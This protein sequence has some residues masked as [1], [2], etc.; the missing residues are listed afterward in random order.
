MSAPKRT[1]AERV[2]GYFHDANGHFNFYG[3]CAVATFWLAVLRGALWI[4]DFV[5]TAVAR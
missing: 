1:V 4:I 3:W 5:V 2:E